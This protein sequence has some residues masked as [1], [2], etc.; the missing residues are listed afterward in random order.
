MLPHLCHQPELFCSRGSFAAQLS[1]HLWWNLPE[2]GNRET[3]SIPCGW[4]SETMQYECQVPFNLFAFQVYQCQQEWVLTGWITSVIH[5]PH[6]S[7]HCENGGGKKS[8]QKNC[9]S[10]GHYY[11]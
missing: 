8:G 9:T 5:M 6:V 11:I 3:P 4:D 10:E 2:Y 7:E 1:Y